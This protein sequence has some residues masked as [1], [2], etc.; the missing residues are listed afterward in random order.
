MIDTDIIDFYNRG[1]E[2]ERLK[3]ARRS[4]E[5][6]RTMDVLQRFLPPP[7]ATILDVGGGPG[8]YA[9]TLAAL[10]YQV[11]LIDPVPLHVEQAQASSDLAEHRLASARLG[12]ARD[13]SQADASADAVLLLGPL[14]HLTTVADRHQAWSEARRV[15]R[16]DGMVVA[17]G[18]S[19][20]YTI[21]E[22][23]SKGILNVPG[24]EET[25]QQHIATGQ[26][27]NPGRDFERLWTTAYFHDPH[28]LASEAVAAG[29]AVRAL[30][31][32]EGPAKLL[33]D[34]ADRMRDS[35]SREQVVAAIRR[36][37]SEPSVLGLS[38]HILV[39]AD[40]APAGKEER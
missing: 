15:L 8:L 5:Y 40:K 16:P 35:V 34:L 24:A 20:Y 18:A 37:E 1:L 30:F 4:I 27:R 25:V 14:Y 10:G 38:S 36:L 3:D 2:Q 17:A 31:A 29:L 39:I 12:D 13:L 9:L 23:L 6:H 11:H 28:E 19:R 26:H 21:W 7:P 33:P 32:V 22:M